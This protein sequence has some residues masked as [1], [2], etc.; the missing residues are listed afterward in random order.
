LKIKNRKLKIM[1]KIFLMAAMAMMAVQL[2]AQTVSL[3]TYMGAQLTTEDLNGTARYVGMGG[4]MEALG[5]EISTISTNPAGLGLFRRSMI[6]GSFGLVSQSDGKSFQNGSKTSA[7]FDQL[8]V[9][10]STRTGMHSYLNYGFNFHK[11]R[12]FNHVLSAAAKA[13]NGSSQNLQTTI[14]GVNGTLD[15]TYGESQVDNLYM[16][17]IEDVDGSLFYYSSDDYTF[18][19]SQTGY[20]GEYEFNIS[21]NMKNRV[22]L[23]MTVGLKSV[24]YN[25]Y[26]EYT[27]TLVPLL[28]DITYVGMRD[29]HRITGTGF[30]I[31]AGIIVRPIEESP[32]RI[33]ASVSSPTF[34]KL[35]TKNTTSIH[36]IPNTFSQ[37]SMV[38][39]VTSDADFRLNT[40]WKF[41]LSLG[42]TIGNYLALGASYEYSDYTT[43]DMRSISGSGYD[44]DG[45]Y[46]ENSNSD[47]V[48]KRHTENTLRG[49][50]TLKLGAEYKV[51][52]SI[53]VRVGYNYV[54]PMYQES[55]VRDLT[56]NSPSTYM[57]S[58]TDYTNWEDTHRLTAGVGFTFDKFRLDLAYQYSMRSGQFYPYMKNIS[59]QYIDY[60]G[61]TQTLTNSSN[62]VSVKDNRHQLL[63]SLSY[64]F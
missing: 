45:Y 35:T 9:V 59:A 22:Y 15:A 19:R 6:S 8:G 1:K 48:V 42:H 36:D 26:T 58:T 16:T 21:G 32:F 30:D 51:D 49:V 64:S 31:K 25:S 57:A 61:V 44:W 10:L 40:P 13:V 52:P 5:A 24:H 17:L 3:D 34:Y 55:G 38:K 28:D 12:N 41:G 14:K 20:I 43:N 7:S 33:G 39:E 4:A 23:G 27:E 63:C 29:D 60:D 37:S 46:Y 47:Q 11:N 56:L 2:Q 18:N 53:A 50:S 62:P 54:S